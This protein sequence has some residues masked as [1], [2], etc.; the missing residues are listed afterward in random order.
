MNV[1]L[2]LL[3]VLLAMVIPPGVYA[4]GNTT[5]SDYSTRVKF[6]YTIGST[7]NTRVS[8]GPQAVGLN[9]S[10]P[11]VY[12]W[13]LGILNVT[14]CFIGPAGGGNA[15]EGACDGIIERTEDYIFTSQ[16]REFLKKDRELRVSNI[17]N[18]SGDDF[19]MLG[20]TVFLII[21]GIFYFYAKTRPQP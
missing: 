21:A 20:M 13:R 12:C 19:F 8:S 9:Y 6:G 7:D 1:R 4:I 11:G 17:I 3:A 5:S 15:T 16:D 2:V 14:G 18:Q 10:T